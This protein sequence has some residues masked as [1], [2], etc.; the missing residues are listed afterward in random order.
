MA[1]RPGT[2]NQTS[3]TLSQ[4]NKVHNVHVNII[5]QMSKTSHDMQWLYITTHNSLTSNDISKSLMKLVQAY[6]SSEPNEDTRDKIIIDSGAT[7]HMVPHHSWFC[8]YM[9]LWTSCPVTLGNDAM[10][11]ATGIG[12]FV[13]SS[14]VNGETYEI[15]LSNILLVPEFQLSLISVNWLS[16][17][18]LST[19]LYSLQTPPHAPYKKDVTWSW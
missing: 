5:N 19:L 3:D 18:R 14:I 9:P 8:S 4:W 2:N 13:V 16:A 17:V 15:T 1:E 12:N 6:L 11:H 7:S 10:T